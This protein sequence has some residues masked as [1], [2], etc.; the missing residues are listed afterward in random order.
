[1]RGLKGL[2]FGVSNAEKRYEVVEVGRVQV[3]L[4]WAEVRMMASNLSE[5]LLASE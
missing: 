4:L 5:L 1:M 3:G 2:L